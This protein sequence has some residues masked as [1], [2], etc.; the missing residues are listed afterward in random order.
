M[1]FQ[2]VEDIQFLLS[3]KKLKALKSIIFKTL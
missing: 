3:T 1:S 2:W